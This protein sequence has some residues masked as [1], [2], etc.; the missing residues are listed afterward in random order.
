MTMTRLLPLLALAALLAACEAKPA[1]T[2]PADTKPAVVTPDTAD[3]AKTPPK[4]EDLARYTADLGSGKLIALIQTSMGP[5]RCQL[6]EDKAPLTVANFVGLARGLKA[7]THPQTNEPQVG[8][9]FYDGLIFHRVI[10]EFMLQGGDPLGLGTGGPGYQIPDEFGPGLKHDRGGLLS[11]ANAGPNTGGSQ[12]FI[13]EVATPWLDGRHAI[14][15]ECDN[16]ELVKKIA[17]V[18]RGPNDRP[19][20]PVR[21]EKISI[22]RSP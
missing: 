13:T 2:K 9:P 7:W 12:F 5:L 16:V 3:T 10:P 22:S 8:K 4:A 15:G 21:I 6:Y 14:F 1:D 17:R 19:V 11:M 20:Q 18:E